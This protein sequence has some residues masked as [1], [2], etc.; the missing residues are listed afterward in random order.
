[1]LNSGASGPVGLND[2]PPVQ[3]EQIT[4]NQSLPNNDAMI[5]AVPVQQSTS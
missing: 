1:M 4:T 5:A 2:S 3:T